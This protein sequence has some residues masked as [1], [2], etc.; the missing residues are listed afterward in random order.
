[1]LDD[2]FLLLF[3]AGAEPVDFALARQVGSGWS[4]EFDTAG[5]GA[6]RVSKAVGRKVTV[7][8]HAVVVLGRRCA[9][10]SPRHPSLRGAK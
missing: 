8:A 7:A 2:D 1:V 9:V 4:F 5:R 10:L 6:G 3:N